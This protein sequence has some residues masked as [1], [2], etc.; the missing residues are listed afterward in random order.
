[1]RHCAAH[2]VCIA[3]PLPP[4]LSRKGQSPDCKQYSRIRSRGLPEWISRPRCPRRSWRASG[5]LWLRFSVNLTRRLA[6]TASHGTFL[7][8]APF[9]SACVPSDHAGPLAIQD[10]GCADVL[11]VG[12]VPLCGSSDGQWYAQEAAEARPLSGK[13][14]ATPHVHAEPPQ[15]QV[16][17]VW[18]LSSCL[19]STDFSSCGDGAEK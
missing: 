14:L 5:V 15:L 19:M 3:P 18:T 9:L 11:S 6:A 10:T 2:F 17:S 7:A 1:M 16:P 13:L 4:V 8:H 12:A